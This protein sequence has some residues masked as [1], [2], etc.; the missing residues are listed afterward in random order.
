MLETGANIATIFLLMEFLIVMLL[1][2]AVIILLARMS[3]VTRR[4][5]RDVMPSLQYKA[6]QLSTTSESV[7]QKVAEPFIRAEQSQARFRGM[8]QRAFGGSQVQPD[9]QHQGPKE[10]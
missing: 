9:S 2:L 5:V 8:R 7:S 1:T 3:L 10:Q 4:K 6:R